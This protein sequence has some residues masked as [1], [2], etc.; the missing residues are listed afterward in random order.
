MESD[1]GYVKRKQLFHWQESLWISLFF[2]MT[3]YATQILLID[4]TENTSFKYY[5][6]ILC[7]LYNN[8]TQEE[9]LL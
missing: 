3:F 9:L 1:W 5:I 4:Y 8:I 2:M 6:S 7:K